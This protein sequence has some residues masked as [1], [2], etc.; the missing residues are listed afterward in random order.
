GLV[1]DGMM[2]F[3]GVWFFLT[4]REAFTI[5]DQDFRIPGIGSYMSEAVK[6]QEYAGMFWAIFAM[7]VMIVTL[8]QLLWRPVVVWAQKFRIEEGGQQM[9]MSSWVLDWLRRSRLLRLA[10]FRLHRRERAA[11]H[12]PAPGKDLASPAPRAVGSAVW[13]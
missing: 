13:L 3:A 12:R 6:N 9:R 4:I 1:W 5:G 11:S 2:S 10:R 7:A 8:D